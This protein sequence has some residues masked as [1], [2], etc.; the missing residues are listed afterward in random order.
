MFN[1]EI[2]VSE[3]RS[4]TETEK[5]FCVCLNIKQLVR[6]DSTAQNHC[7]IVRNKL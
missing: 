4:V 3:S 6:K 5:H 2:L 7:I 1:G